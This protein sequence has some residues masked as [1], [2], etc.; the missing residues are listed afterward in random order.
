MH[1][2]RP[3][4]LEPGDPKL[5]CPPIFDLLIVTEHRN[6]L[7]TI[8]LAKG[9]SKLDG[10]DQILTGSNDFSYPIYS[11]LFK[12]PVAFSLTA[13]GIPLRPANLLKEVVGIGPRILDWMFFP[14][15][16]LI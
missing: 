10:I 2:A 7:V 11:A 5:F 12:Y 8:E 1:Q 6:A 3:F 15:R 9:G 14:F 13:K 16:L 4:S